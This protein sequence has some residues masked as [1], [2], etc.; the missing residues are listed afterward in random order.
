MLTAEA[1][2]VE[3]DGESTQVLRNRAMRELGPMS[4]L[5]PEFPSAAAAMASSPRPS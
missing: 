1:V 2:T 5:A 4:D 3:G